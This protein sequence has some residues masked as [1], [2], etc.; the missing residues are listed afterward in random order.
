MRHRKSRIYICFVYCDTHNTMQNDAMICYE[1][2][3][4]IVREHEST[5]AFGQS[6]S[7]HRREILA[8]FHVLRSS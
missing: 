8:F 1:Y 6:S 2:V 4:A 5:F 3:F 7:Q